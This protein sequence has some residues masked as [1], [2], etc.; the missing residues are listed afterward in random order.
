MKKPI[1]ELL[2]NILKQNHQKIR[3]QFTPFQGMRKIL[4]SVFEYL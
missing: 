4:N 1:A 3:F 2:V